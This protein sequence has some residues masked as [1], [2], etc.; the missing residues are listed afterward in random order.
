MV[1]DAR[2]VADYL[3]ARFGKEKIYLVGHS[4]GTMLGSLLV[5]RYPE[6]FAG[7]CAIGQVVYGVDNERVSYAWT[8]GQARVRGDAKGIKAL[9]AIA[10]YG[11]DPHT[12]WARNIMIERKWLG[13]YG[14]A[15]GHD[16]SFERALVADV[17]VSP[18]YT[19]VDKVNFLRGSRRSLNDLWPAVLDLDVRKEASR[20]EVPVLMIA[21]R[22][23]YNTPCSLAE[24]YFNQL[25]A[26]RKEF[27]WFEHSAHAPCFEEPA[28]FADV[29]T[30][31]FLEG[32]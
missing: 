6:K 12:D 17:V 4:W 9:E 16:P 25:A 1:D 13:A 14:G 8:L 28:K 18:E 3:R 26:P 5:V 24:S 29:V 32:K 7:W 27:A 10:G 31:F 23:D 15:T 20:I 2:A 21:G 19:L 11:E 22:Y 30:A